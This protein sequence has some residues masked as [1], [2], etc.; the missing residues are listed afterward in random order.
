MAPNRVL[1]GFGG[2]GRLGQT[3]DM[4]PPSCPG[5]LRLA[6]CAHSCKCRVFYKNELL[7]SIFPLKVGPY[8]N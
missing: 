3:M 6:R 4:Q 2:F 8:R 1:G 7:D 5:A